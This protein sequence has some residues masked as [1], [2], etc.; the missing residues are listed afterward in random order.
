MQPTYH[1]HNAFKRISSMHPRHISELDLNLLK[2][3]DALLDTRSVTLSAERLGIGQPAASRALARLRKVLDDPLLVRTPS[4]YEL[5][6][7]AIRLKPE[8]VQAM[9]A[10]DRVFAPPS[11]E[12]V[13][14]TRRF[15]IATTDY[16]SMAVL[17]QAVPALLRSAP[18]ASLDV[19][20]WSES[21][22]DDMAGGGVDLA[23]YAD[24]ALPAAYAWRRLFTET[25]V[26][27][28]RRGH[29][30]HQLASAGS[31]ASRLKALGKYPRAV[32]AYPSGRVTQLD[33]LLDQ[34]GLRDGRVS[35]SL[36]YFLAAPWIIAE[37]DLVLV[38]P[39]RVATRLA[40][41]ARLDSSPFPVRGKGFEY[42]MIWHE[43]MHRE[44]AHRWL[45]EL[46]R[47]N[48]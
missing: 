40:S 8:V 23:L 3:L 32:I 22:L 35:L 34:A 43:R 4:G 30:V 1:A 36:P 48:L 38:A 11:F 9:H 2:L 44:L 29:P 46:I 17:N 37:S 21:T 12:A 39:A 45:R 26:C 13:T 28:Y 47:K 25:F 42:R 33:D 7:R 20:P 27:L 18:H 41:V 14:S 19:V 24:D 6:P 10:L 31:N 16:G 15:R 5:T